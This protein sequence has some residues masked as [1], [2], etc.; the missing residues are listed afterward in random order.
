MVNLYAKQ[1][2][3]LAAVAAL[4]AAC[5]LAPRTAAVM[6]DSIETNCPWGV[7]DGDRYVGIQLIG[8]QSCKTVGGLGCTGEICRLCKVRDTPQ[9]DHLFKCADFG[10]VF[11]SAE[12]SAPTPQ[13]TPSPSPSIDPPSPTICSVSDSDFASGVTAVWDMS[14]RRGGVGC[15]NSKCRYCQWK[16]TPLSAHLT[17][18]QALAPTPAPTTPAPTTPTPTTPAPTTPTPTTPAPLTPEPTLAPVTINTTNCP[19]SA[20]PEDKAMGMDLVGDDS[21]DSGGLGCFNGQC[22]WCR[23]RETPMSSHLKSCLDLGYDLQPWWPPASSA[24]PTVHPGWNADTGCP[25]NVSAGDIAAGI[26]LV[27]I[28]DT[29][30]QEDLGCLG[31]IFGIEDNVRV[32]CRLCKFRNTRRSANL[33]A[34]PSLGYYFLPPKATPCG[35]SESDFTAG[36]NA[37]PDVSCATGGEGCYTASCRLCQWKPTPQSAHM[38]PCLSVATDLGGSNDGIDL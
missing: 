16:E 22:R 14:C 18:C 8:D 12:T 38:L 1:P 24:P 19:W 25:W 36:V 3:A 21:C 7:S 27:G 20:S 17:P 35:V 5:A 10:Y 23:V 29:Y 26:Q 33:I 34:C 6:S 4:V 30:K 15:Y 31:C 11:G 32:Q 9:S 2:Q 28:P 13:P 37:V